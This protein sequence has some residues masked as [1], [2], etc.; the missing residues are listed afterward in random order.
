MWR[1]AGQQR[2]RAEI[3]SEEVHSQNNIV[4]SCFF[5]GCQ[6]ARFTSHWLKAS[7]QVSQ[8]NKGFAWLTRFFEEQ[9]REHCKESRSH[10]FSTLILVSLQL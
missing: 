1:T 9:Q 3:A 4:F 5:I 8:E 7:F 10:P 2:H 6:G